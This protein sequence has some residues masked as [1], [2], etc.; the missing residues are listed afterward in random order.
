MF[1]CNFLYQIF[2]RIEVSLSSIFSFVQHA[3]IH[4]LKSL[5]MIMQMNNYRFYNL[6]Y[7]KSSYSYLRRDTKNCEKSINSVTTVAGECV[8][9]NGTM[10]TCNQFSTADP[11][12]AP[13]TSSPIVI[14]VAL[15]TKKKKRKWLQIFWSK[16]K[17]KQIWNSRN[18]C[19]LKYW[20]AL[21]ERVIN[22]NGKLPFAL[23]LQ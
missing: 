5:V 6:N 16:L 7:K 22:P 12:T 17:L 13:A 2:R 19:S 10:S 9:R 4:I 20:H 14:I 8:P 21:A 23:G 1:Q 15:P 18:R 11:T 3:M